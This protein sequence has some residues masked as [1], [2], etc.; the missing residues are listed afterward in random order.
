MFILGANGCGKT[1]LFKIIL[2]KISSD[3]GRIEFGVNVD[4]GYFDQVQENLNLE[5]TALDEVWDMFP[6]MT[7]TQ[8]RTA[9]GSF[10][11]KGD[12]VFKK[13]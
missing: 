11:F 5:N 9:L 4:T 3:S 2:N 13:M 6:F 10:L 8:V 12:D 7:Q 1:T